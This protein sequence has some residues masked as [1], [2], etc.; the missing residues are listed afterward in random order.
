MQDL[1]GAI[2]SE[3]GRWRAMDCSM[4]L[5][6]ACRGAGGDWQLAAG[7][8]GGCPPGYTWEVPHHAKENMQLQTLLKMSP[9]PPVNA[10]WL[11]VAGVAHSHTCHVLCV[12]MALSLITCRFAVLVHA[13]LT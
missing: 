4:V 5:P 12:L 8:R 11:P 9:G 3:D 7:T 10:A 6:T 2:S 13:A 1:C